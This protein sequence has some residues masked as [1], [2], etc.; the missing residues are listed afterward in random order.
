MLVFSTLA[1]LPLILFVACKLEEFP[2]LL[3]AHILEPAEFAPNW[4]LP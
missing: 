3:E 2:N 4:A 1:T